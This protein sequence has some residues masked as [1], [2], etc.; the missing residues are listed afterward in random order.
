MQMY[1]TN[2]AVVSGETFAYKATTGPLSNL[3]FAFPKA[4]NEADISVRLF[5]LLSKSKLLNQCT[6]SVDIL[7][8]QIIQKTTSLTY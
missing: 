8:L 2:S 4:Q 6:I 1:F 5:K 3:I 7:L